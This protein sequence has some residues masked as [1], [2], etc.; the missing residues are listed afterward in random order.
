MAQPDVSDIETCSLQLLSGCVCL[1]LAP[2]DYEAVNQTLTFDATNTRTTVPITIVNDEVDENEENFISRLSLEPV[3][4]D[5]PNVQL[6]PDQA[7]LLIGDDD[8]QLIMNLD[9]IE[10][11]M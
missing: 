6:Q 3:V 2:D 1:C 7:T 4:G 5:P 11:D 9:W 10:Y 8:G